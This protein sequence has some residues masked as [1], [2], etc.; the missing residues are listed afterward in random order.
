MCKV[1]PTRPVWLFS[2]DSSR[3]PDAAPLTTGNLKAHFVKYGA[4]AAL[5]EVEIVHFASHLDVPLWFATEWLE[6]QRARAGRAID[7]GLRPVAGIS[8]YTW[9]TEEFL[10]LV[11]R[12]KHSVPGLLVVAGGPQVQRPEDYLGDVVDVV[13]LG[14]GEWTF[15]DILD[16]TMDASCAVSIALERVAGVAYRDCFGG[17]RRTPARER[18]R[19]LDELAPALDVVELRDGA[20]ASRYKRAAYETT[21]GCPFS[22]AF[23]EW[24]TGAT[25]TKMFEYSL[26]RIRSDLERLVQG[27]VEEIFFCDSNFGALRS[28]EDKAGILI[29]LREEYGRP[30]IFCTSWSKNHNPRVQQIVR[31]LNAAGLI[32]HYTLALETLTPL[33]LQLSHR[34]NMPLNRFERI[35]SDMA[36]QRIP[37]TTELI[38]ALPGDNL[39][40]FEKNLDLLTAIFPSSS[41]YGYTLL[42][43]TE[44]FERRQEYQIETVTLREIGNW[45]LDYVVACHTF[46]REEGCR[47]YFLIT[48][49]NILNRGNLIPLTSRFIALDGRAS[50]S[51]VLQEALES[52]LPGLG[53]EFANCGADHGLD[54]Y[55]MRDRIYWRLLET[56]EFAFER[57]RASIEKTLMRRCPDA[58]E[59]VERVGKILSIDEALCPRLPGESEPT[60]YGFDFDAE[61]IYQSLSRMQLPPAAAF[62]RGSGSTLALFRPSQA[63][64]VLAPDALEPNM[65][66]S[67]HAVVP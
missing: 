4:T 22:C 40:D 39:K 42:P 21:R 47:G 43:G 8:C 32:E 25:G 49:H 41:L 3:Y 53:A 38:W 37:I 28:D 1:T 45:K 52:I 24:G 58:S 14:E 20:G 36:Q 63:S 34:S 11:R 6:T 15:K 67:H 23:C 56:R 26:G 61:S 65:I 66:R 62:E 16:S 18:T 59:L 33:A 2:L 31:S 51:Y 10:N 12:M 9:N 19:V 50:V 13:V 46:T 30:V 54:T 60:R 64:H 55:A 44:F 5:S 48:A 27:G 29:G 7:M 57:L 35:V 17:V